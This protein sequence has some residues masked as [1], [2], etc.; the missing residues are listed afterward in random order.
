[1]SR[2]RR[3]KPPSTPLRSV[4]RL[5]LL[6]ALGGL[7]LAALTFL[8]RGAP[9]NLLLVTIDTLR[10]DHVGAYGAT[11]ASTPVLDALAKRGILFQSAHSAVPLTGPSHATILTGLYPPAHGVR[12]NAT[13]VL[14]PEH[15]TLASLLKAKGYSTAGFVAAL[16]LVSAFGFA[17]SFQ[18]PNI[19]PH[20]R[21]DRRFHRAGVNARCGAPRG[22]PRCR[23]G[24]RSRPR[25]RCRCAA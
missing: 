2:R 9:R 8:W 16:P 22:C 6:A 5:I 21:R 23:A 13:F 25:G 15:R 20:Q 17:K 4:R 11:G 12:D 14:A 19:D 1:M 18:N 3:A 7:A 24:S 10:A